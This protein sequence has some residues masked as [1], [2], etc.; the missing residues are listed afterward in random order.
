MEHV[1]EF[2]V[3][4]WALTG[5]FVLLLLWLSQVST[6]KVVKG[7]EMLTPGE[8]I[9]KI[10]KEQGVLIDIRDESKF[11]QGHIVNSINMQLSLLES[12]T[13][14]LQKYKTK[15]IIMV[16]QLGQPAVKAAKIMKDNGFETVFCLKGGIQA[17]VADELPLVQS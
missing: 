13:K 4:H 10:N 16:C 14:K 5:T 9:Q 11:G 3:E 8:C 17:W 1:L 7:V 6:G 15:P 2:L 12:D